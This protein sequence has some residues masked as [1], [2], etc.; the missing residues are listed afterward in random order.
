[1]KPQETYEERYKRAKERVGEIRG[2]YSHSVVYILVNIGIA[3][4]N[5][6][7]NQ[8]EFPWFLFTLGGWGIGL[9]AHAFAIFGT[10]PFTGKKWE[11]RKIQ[12]I[13][14]KELNS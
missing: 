10:N 11:E 9:I 8:W 2:F 13:M 7:Q 4:L 1:M 5:Y 3:G 14:E 6:Y 12:E